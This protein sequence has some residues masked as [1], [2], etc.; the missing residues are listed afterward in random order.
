MHQSHHSKIPA[1]AVAVL[2]SAPV[3]AQGAITEQITIHADLGSSPPL[4]LHF[5]GS[6]YLP[7]GIYIESSFDKSTE[8]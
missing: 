2:A 1:L 3:S 5:D 8:S 7:P 6:G 4:S